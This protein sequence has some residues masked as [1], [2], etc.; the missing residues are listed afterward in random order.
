[1]DFLKHKL[2]RHAY[3][4]R[5][6]LEEDHEVAGCVEYPIDRKHQFGGTTSNVDIPDC[7]FT[8]HTHPRDA[9]IENNVEMAWPS[10]EDMAAMVSTPKNLGHAVIS[11][12]GV[13]IM[14]LT[15]ET[16]NKL[17]RV[18]SKT[19]DDV[20]DIIQSIFMSTHDFRQKKLMTP[21]DFVKWANNFTLNSVDGKSAGS[22]CTMKVCPSR[23]VPTPYTDESW[24]IDKWL[25]SQG[26]KKE[27]FEKV[28][29]VVGPTSKI[30][31]VEFIPWK[32][33]PQ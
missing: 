30:V 22:S 11:L 26:I 15:P 1:M 18:S 29:K 24:T 12:E 8:Y 14:T 28:K 13:Y 10:G 19:V 21:E 2:L 4:L 17:S 3:S 23:N 6:L 25:N 9:Y 7:A 32:S 5:E 27:K 31:Q 20:A 16:K 33:I